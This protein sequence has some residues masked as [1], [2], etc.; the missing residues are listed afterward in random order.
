MS[1][2]V[3]YINI[4]KEIQRLRGEGHAVLTASAAVDQ[5]RNV[6]GMRQTT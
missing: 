3:E 1:R 5:Y 6:L 4:D 2:F